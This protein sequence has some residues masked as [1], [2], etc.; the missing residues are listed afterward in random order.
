[1]NN[2]EIARILRNIAIS[3]QILGENRFK[4]IAYEK[5][6]DTVENLAKS[7]KDIWSDGTLET[8]AGL[9]KTIAGHI[10]ELFRTGN[11]QHFETVLSKIPKSIFILLDIP[12]LGPKK[13]YKLITAF[14]LNNPQTAVEGLK[15]AAEGHRIAHLEGFGDRSEQ[16]ILTSIGLY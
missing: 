13:A 12:G 2:H 8:E 6:A 14:R 3:Y 1:M 10:D 11:V 5:A 4:T 16:D 15:R 7:L 9:G